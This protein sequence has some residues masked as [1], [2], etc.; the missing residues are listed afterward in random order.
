MG[1]LIIFI[2]LSMQAYAANC[3]GAV[4]CNCGDN[5]TTSRNLSGA[6]N[7]TG[8]ASHGLIINT[9]GVT[10]DCN[11]VTISGAATFYGI[12][13]RADNVV[14]SDCVIDGF[15]HGI[16]LF[17]VN[18]SDIS[19]NNITNIVNGYGIYLFESHN[20]NMTQNEVINC[21]NGAI[22]QTSNNNNFNQ[23][24]LYIGQQGLT[25]MGSYGNT[26]TSNNIEDFT[27]GGGVLSS[28]NEHFISNTITSHGIGFQIQSAYNNVFRS[29]TVSYNRDAGLLIGSNSHDNDYSLN[30]FNDNTRDAIMVSNSYGENFTSNDF[31]DNNVGIHIH[32]SNSL[33]FNLNDFVD[34]TQGIKMLHSGLNTFEQN[35][36][37]NNIY[38]I[39][40][41]NST[42]NIFNQN[43][44]TG[45]GIGFLIDANTN[46]NTLRSNTICPNAIDMTSSGTNNG[47]NN[48]CDSPGGW[49]DT[50]MNGCTNR[51]T[52]RTPSGNSCGGGGSSTPPIK[53]HLF[54]NGFS[55]YRGGVFHFKF[56]DVDYKINIERYNNDYSILLINL[57]RK[58]Y[59]LVIGEP[60]DLDINNDGQPDIKLTY[61]GVSSSARKEIVI[62]IEPY[63]KIEN[64]AQVQTVA[65]EVVEED[66]IIKTI[67][68]EVKEEKIV[69][70]IPKVSKNKI[71]IERNPTNYLPIGIAIMA[72]S[73][74]GLL[75]TGYFIRRR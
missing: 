27:L 54:D 46:G 33:I 24:N 28:Y 50:S 73:I 16:L 23:N 30:T 60:F 72:V 45:S 6:D 62:K 5:L 44:I 56:N 4:A 51:C 58:G 75:L 71:K 14:V 36:L 65:V 19:S 41:S 43:T 21:F 1:F 52:P 49:D 22:L 13:I 53:F 57:G 42:L 69:E 68:E 64:V 67:V 7:L 25:S 74:I 40:V 29:N 17:R 34:N 39:N 3:G 9:S 37:T 12:D 2:V 38:G 70:T 55:T 48:T 8:C 32:T 20:N 26:Y 66:P 18:G 59:E 11:G 63:E 10:L 47:L 35:T 15:T 61:E 31:N